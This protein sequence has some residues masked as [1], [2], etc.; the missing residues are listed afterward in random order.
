MTINRQLVVG[1]CPVR[2]AKNLQSKLRFFL[3]WTLSICNSRRNTYVHIFLNQKLTIYLP[4]LTILRPIKI[5]IALILNT[6]RQEV[7]NE[8]IEYRHPYVN[9]VLWFT[10]D[11]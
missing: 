11:D 5:L 8:N 9:W 1:S 3:F 7:L 6:H 10:N 4:I 2:T